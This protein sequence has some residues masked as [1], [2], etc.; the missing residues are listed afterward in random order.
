[1]KKFISFLT[2]I[3]TLLFI[4]CSSEPAKSVTAPKEVYK[5][6][7]KIELKSVAGAK[8]TLLRKKSGFV[9]EG[10]EDKII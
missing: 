5:E 6:G 4:G 1:M 10:N 7:D 8:I 9:I 2:I 3:S